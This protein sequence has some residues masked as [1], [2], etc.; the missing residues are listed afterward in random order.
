[1]YSDRV[2]VVVVVVVC[3]CLGKIHLLHLKN[4]LSI[5]DCL[6]QPVDPLILR[7]LERQGGGFVRQEAEVEGVGYRGVA[8]IGLD[9][10]LIRGFWESFPG[11]C[12]S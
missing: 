4:G 7:G 5:I 6:S 11:A 8:D 10:S 12:P 2:V 3:V 9:F 1:M